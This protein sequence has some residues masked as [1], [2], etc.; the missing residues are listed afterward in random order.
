MRGKFI[1]SLQ[2][3]VIFACE[4]RAVGKLVTCNC[5]ECAVKRREEESSRVSSVLR[6]IRRSTVLVVLLPGAA[7]PIGH[8]TPPHL[9]LT[10]FYS[11]MCLNWLRVVHKLFSS[12]NCTLKKT[13][14]VYSSRK[15]VNMDAANR[16]FK[17]KCFRKMKS[18]EM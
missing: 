4:L 12:V 15:H 6:K 1:A 16:N 17:G 3:P 2:F 13:R 8:P 18:S 7:R 5:V 11:V 9:V 14:V 10:R